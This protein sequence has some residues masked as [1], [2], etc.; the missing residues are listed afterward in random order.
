MLEDVVYSETLEDSGYFV[1]ILKYSV[2]KE[3]RDLW[4]NR[5]HYYDI[6]VS[7]N[8]K[9]DTFDDVYECIYTIKE[10]HKLFKLAKKQAII[11]YQEGNKKPVSEI[12]LNELET[13]A[14]QVAIDS[15]INNWIELRD[16][17]TLSDL[18]GHS[19]YI[20]NI[21]FDYLDNEYR[22]N[23]DCFSEDDISDYEDIL[24]AQKSA[25]KK[26]TYTV[27]NKKQKEK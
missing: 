13:N 27:I 18:N 17:K 8:D 1:S 19:E 23:K 5:N 10:A 4:D 25:L 9:N 6:R 22:C 2:E 15:L 26:I 14:V 20:L 24:K 16:S 12:K 11:E 3:Y 21:I 7:Y